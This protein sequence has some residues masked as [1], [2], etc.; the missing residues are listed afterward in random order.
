MYISMNAKDVSED[1]GIY[2]EMRLAIGMAKPPYSDE[3]EEEHGRL[4]LEGDCATAD[5]DHSVPELAKTLPL[6]PER[7]IFALD[8]VRGIA[9]LSILVFH[10]FQAFPLQGRISRIVWAA[11]MSG[12]SGVDLFFVLSGFLITGILWNSRDT[13]NY[14]RVFYGRR[15][16]RIFPLYYLAVAIVMFTLTIRGTHSSANAESLHAQGW[17]WLYGINFLCA[18]WS[19]WALVGTWFNLSLFWSLAIEEQFYLIWPLVV[20]RLSRITLMHLCAWAMVVAMLLRAVLYRGNPGHWMAPYVL[21]PCRMDALAA[22]AFVAMAMRGEGSRVRLVA[23]A[24]WVCGATGFMLF[25]WF[26]GAPR[27]VPFDPFNL[28][29]SFSAVLAHSIFAVFFASAIAVI[30]SSRPKALFR[31]ACEVGW[32]RSFGKYS[33]GL[34]VYQA[35]IGVWFS[36]HLPL[37]VVPGFAYSQ[38][39]AAILRAAIGIACLFAVSFISWHLYEKQWLKLKRYFQYH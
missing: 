23:L 3:L 1:T 18:Y 5:L 21:T 37:A 4:A 20:R 17:A 39:L 30:V 19:R 38:L 34:Y 2:V 15:T 16:V 6:S 29:Y 24:P 32:L 7:H 35:L 10:S 9:V 13:S 25:G 8:G 14:F 22:G 36:N 27:L 31:R 26:V 33:Y 11:V 28:T 12:W